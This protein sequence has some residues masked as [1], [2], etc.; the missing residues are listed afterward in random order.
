MEMIGLYGSMLL[1]GAGITCFGLVRS[2]SRYTSWRIENARDE[3]EIV[4]G[5]DPL[6]VGQALRLA[7]GARTLTT[8]P[9]GPFDGAIA[10][11]TRKHC[12]IE[13]MG[14]SPHSLTAYRLAAPGVAGASDGSE[15]P[16]LWQ[17]PA[18]EESPLWPQPGAE[19]TVTVTAHSELYRFTT[20]VKD[21]QAAPSGVRVF[22]GRP[23]FLVRIQRRRSARTR[24]CLP[25]TF[26]LA[27]SPAAASAPVAHPAGTLLHGT[28]KDL[29]AGGLRA[30]IGG[31]SRLAELDR[32]LATFRP[33]STVRIALPFP[34]LRRDALLARVRSAGRGVTRGG[35]TAQITCE[36]LPMPH[37]EQEIL[38]QQ[39]FELQRS[40][41]RAAKMRRHDGQPGL[42]Q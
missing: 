34:A 20:R 7:P 25:A 31:V 23:P 15:D 27:A 17:Q 11:I 41:L 14:L 8:D 40:E 18:S 29:S 22:L 35:L 6:Q 13:L 16:S 21:V 1:A 10:E 24:L 30:D 19:V 26:E 9:P 39:V 32:L 37:W 2:L 36:F 4:L 12:V 42:S 38:V 5:D 33:G 28:V 3:G